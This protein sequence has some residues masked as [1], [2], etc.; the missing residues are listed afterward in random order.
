MTTRWRTTLRFRDGWTVP[1]AERLA[2]ADWLAVVLPKEADVD[3][4]TVVPTAAGWIVSLSLVAADRRDV[5]DT[6][7]ALIDL[8][9]GDSGRVLGRLV[10]T[11]VLPL[12]E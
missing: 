11:R 10:E 4:V 3:P 7:T 6:A 9:V 1:A 12:R 8:V 2:T 5:V